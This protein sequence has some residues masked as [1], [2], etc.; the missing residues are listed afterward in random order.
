MYYEQEILCS[1]CCNN[2]TYLDKEKCNEVECCG[3]SELYCL[4]I[5]NTST[6]VYIIVNILGPLGPHV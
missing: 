6:W 4:N 5:W 2:M 1:S 3:M